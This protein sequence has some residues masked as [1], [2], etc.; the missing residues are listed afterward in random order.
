MFVV[1]LRLLPDVVGA[2]TVGT[3]LLFFTSGERRGLHP[4]LLLLFPLD[5]AAHLARLL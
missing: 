3:C 4:L 1:T 2:R 5:A